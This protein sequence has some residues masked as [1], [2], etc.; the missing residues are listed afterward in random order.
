[1]TSSGMTGPLCHH[2]LNPSGNILRN[3]RLNTL[4]NLYQ[5]VPNLL[6]HLLPLL[7]PHERTRL[8]H[9]AGVDILPMSLLPSLNRLHQGP[10]SLVI[11]PANKLVE[12]A[13]EDADKGGQALEQVGFA[14]TRVAAVNDDGVVGVGL[15]Q[16]GAEFLDEEQGQELAGGVALVQGGAGLEGIEDVGGGLLG[17]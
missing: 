17:E 8:R 11:G 13:K 3:T 14:N 6:L 10:R 15:G 2:H 12:G 7:R 16:T 4:Q 1:M 5:L 9:L